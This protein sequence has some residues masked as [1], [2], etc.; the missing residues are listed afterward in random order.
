MDVKVFLDWFPMFQREEE[1]ET[2]KQGKDCVFDGALCFYATPKHNEEGSELPFLVG[3]L[4]TTDPHTLPCVVWMDSGTAQIEMAGGLYTLVPHDVLA[5][6]PPG[7]GSDAPGLDLVSS[8]GLTAR[9]MGGWEDLVGLADALLSRITVAQDREGEGGGLDQSVLQTLLAMAQS[10]C[11]GLDG[12]EGVA[13]QEFMA[14]KLAPR[15][16]S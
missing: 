16:E 11:G 9:L 4:N 8:C 13:L 7:V 15:T 10:G 2:G 12:G 5:L 1:G 6:I 14:D 3:L